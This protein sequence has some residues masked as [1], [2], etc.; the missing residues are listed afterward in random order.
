MLE[1]ASV[2]GRYLIM[3]DRFRNSNGDPLDGGFTFLVRTADSQS[4]SIYLVFDKTTYYSIGRPTASVP[5]LLTSGTSTSVGGNT[6]LFPYYSMIPGGTGLKRVKM[7]L[8]CPTSDFGFNS[9]NIVNHL[10]AN[11]TYK[12]L[13]DRY[14][15]MDSRNQQYASAALWWED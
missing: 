4:Y 1:N 10:A 6:Y 12:M 15:A 9:N 7:L 14:L 8:C 3:I 13:G 2:H 11:R 5:V